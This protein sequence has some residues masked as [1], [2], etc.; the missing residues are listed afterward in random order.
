MPPS[1]LTLSNFYDF[2]SLLTEKISDLFF[3]EYEPET[4]FVMIVEYVRGRSTFE[5]SAIFQ[6][7]FG[8]FHNDV[9]QFEDWKNLVFDGESD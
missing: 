7:L 2:F 3:L 4:T 6:T 1:A 5:E 9:F 8:N